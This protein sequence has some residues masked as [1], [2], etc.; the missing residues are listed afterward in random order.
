MT[1]R[2]PWAVFLV[3]VVCVYATQAITAQPM[4]L[5]EVVRAAESIT[6]ARVLAVEPIWDAE[7]GMPFTEVSYTIADVLKGPLAID[8]ALSLRC[9]GGPAPNGLTLRV[10]GMPRFEV[11]D[12]AMLFSALNGSEMICP[13]V[14]WQQGVY[15]IRADGTVTDYAGRAVIGVD[16]NAGSRTARTAAPEGSTA[17]TYEEFA[18]L[19]RQEL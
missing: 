2:L 9:L 18:A 16:G 6:T 15:R 10:S 17:L 1:M 12:V 11:G 7:R 8:Q 5:S 19:I 3:A 4:S 14:G 13:L